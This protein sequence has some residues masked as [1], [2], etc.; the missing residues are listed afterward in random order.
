MGIMGYCV[1]GEH[2]RCPNPD[3]SCDCPC[4]LAEDTNYEPFERRISKG[5]TYS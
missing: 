1:L 4:H 2:D 3:D 5:G